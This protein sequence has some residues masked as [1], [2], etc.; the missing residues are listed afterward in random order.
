[1]TLKD[2]IY[3]LGVV[4][5]AMIRNTGKANLIKRTTSQVYMDIDNGSI[6]YL[7]KDF[8]SQWKGIGYSQ[9]G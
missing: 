1:M 8:S 2:V 3:L 4:E 7:E 9:L 5:S 6:G